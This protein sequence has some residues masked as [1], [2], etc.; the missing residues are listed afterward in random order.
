MKDGLCGPALNRRTLLAGAGGL[1][2]GAGLLRPAAILNAAPAVEGAPLV[3]PPELRAAGGVLDTTIN[4]E[5]GYFALGNRAAALRGYNGGPVGPTLRLRGGDTLKLTLANKLPPDCADCAPKLPA[6]LPLN[7]ICTSGGGSSPRSFNITNMHVHGV[8][9][10]P[11]APADDIT[12]PVAPGASYPYAYPIPHDHPPGTYFYHAHIHG[13]VALQVSSGMAGALIIEGP[14]DDIPEIAAARQQVLVF[15]SQCLDADGRCEDFAT[16]NQRQDTYINGQVRP[17]LTLRPGEVQRWRIVNAS[18][19]RFL[20]LRATGLTVRAL[21]Y[22]GNPL[23][24]PEA[25]DVVALAPGNRADILV[26]AEAAGSFQL[27]SDGWP[28][29]N[30]PTQG[31]VLATLSVTGEPMKPMALYEGSL[32]LEHY[33]LLAHLTPEQAMVGRRLTLGQ[34]GNRPEFIFTLDDKPYPANGAL[35]VKLGAVELWEVV[36][37]TSDPHPFHIHVNPVQVVSGGDHA[38]PG[39]WLDTVVLPP[40]GKLRF[41]TRFA[42]FPGTFVFHCHILTHEDLGMMRLITVTA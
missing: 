32:G 22:D 37:Q 21:A 14:L 26:R 28:D 10:S 3:E 13:S 29:W 40:A 17:T 23:A 25:T 8:H 6:N 9:V 39:R 35:E 30:Y 36:N 16:L 11:Q 24:T 31:T 42:D 7:E 4:A 33:P 34:I 27:T 18:H 5:Y 15:Q 1:A 20:L 2:L 12:I 19:D 41:L 38:P